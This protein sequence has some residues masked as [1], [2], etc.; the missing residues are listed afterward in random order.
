MPVRRGRAIEPPPVGVPPYVLCD[1]MHA[2]MCDS[3]RASKLGSVVGGSSRWQMGHSSSSASCGGSG[4]NGRLCA[5][6][7]EEPE[8]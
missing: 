2:L 7:D 8:A 4:G 3:R 5:A 6:A 1:V